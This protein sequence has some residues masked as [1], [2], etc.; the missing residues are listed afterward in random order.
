MMTEDWLLEGMLGIHKEQMVIATLGFV[1]VSLT[2][3]IVASLKKMN[4]STNS[5][6]DAE[7]Y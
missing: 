4:R 2:V 3:G 7:S 1:V 6:I 5:P